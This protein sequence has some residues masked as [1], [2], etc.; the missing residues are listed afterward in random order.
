MLTAGRSEQN[1]WRFFPSVHAYEHFEW[2]ERKG[3]GLAMSFKGAHANLWTG[4]GEI[5]AWCEQERT[6]TVTWCDT[7][8]KDFSKCWMLGNRRWTSKLQICSRQ[9]AE[10][11][12]KRKCQV[13]PDLTKMKMRN[14]KKKNWSNWLYSKF[15]FDRFILQDL[16]PAHLKPGSTA[17]FCSQ[18]DSGLR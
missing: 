2:S 9:K 5:W 8:H 17:Q 1:Q 12:K 14:K 18:F 7:R 4:A 13:L 6:H 11:K 10:L 3:R 15:W 16:L